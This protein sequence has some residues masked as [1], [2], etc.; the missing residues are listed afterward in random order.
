MLHD[1]EGVVCA[2]ML[3]EEIDVAV[4]KAIGAR[5]EREAMFFDAEGRAG[6]VDGCEPFFKFAVGISVALLKCVD[7]GKF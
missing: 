4:V 2:P 7:L 5:E 3:D 6:L 1:A